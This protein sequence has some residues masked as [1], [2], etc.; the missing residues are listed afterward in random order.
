MMLLN[1]SLGQAYFWIPQIQRERDR[2]CLA[3]QK[4]IFSW[5]GRKKEQTWL[6]KGKICKRDEL[7]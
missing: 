2:Q 1:M 5:E 7:S 6:L 3:L 4:P